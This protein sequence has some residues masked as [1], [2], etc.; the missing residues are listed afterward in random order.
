[1][2]ESI[3][4]VSFSG[5]EEKEEEFDDEMKVELS[6]SFYGEEEEEEEEEEDEK[7]LAERWIK[8]SQILPPEE[9]MGLGEAA[10]LID[11]VYGN[12]PCK[13]VDEEQEES[14]AA[15]PWT[16]EDAE[17][18][19]KKQQEYLDK[20]KEYANLGLCDVEPTGDYTTQ[21][22][23]ELSHAE[24][25]YYLNVSGGQITKTVLQTSI[26]NED[27]KNAES[28]ARVYLVDIRVLGTVDGE[29][30]DCTVTG[31]YF[32]ESDEISLS[33]P[34]TD[35]ATEI[36]RGKYCPKKDNYG[37]EFTVREIEDVVRCYE[38]VT[39]QYFCECSG[40]LA[41]EITEEV[42]ISCPEDLNIRCNRQYS[43]WTNGYY[44]DDGN[45]VPGKYYCD[46]YMG[47]RTVLG[48]YISCDIVLYD[49]MGVPRAR[50]E[51]KSVMS[52]AWYYEE[53][54]C[55]PPEG[56]LPKCQTTYRKNPGDGKIDETRLSNYKARYGDKLD[57]I[58][59]SPEDGDC[60]TIKTVI[61]D[62]ALSCCDFVT[63]IV[64]DIEN[65]FE[66][67]GDY[68][69]GYIVFSGGRAPYHVSV[70]G[71]GFHLGNGVRD[72]IVQHTLV[73]IYTAQ[74]C[75]VVK[76]TVDDGCST[77]SGYARATNGS[78]LPVDGIPQPSCHIPGD[79]STRLVNPGD[80]VISGK[81][82]AENIYCDVGCSLR[83][84]I[85][86]GL[87]DLD[88]VHCEDAALLECS[89]KDSEGTLCASFL[90]AF[91][92]S[93]FSTG[94]V[95]GEWETIIAG[96]STLHRWCDIKE[97]DGPC[98]W[99]LL[100]REFSYD[101]GETV[102]A[103]DFPFAPTYYSFACTAIIYEWVC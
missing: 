27:R 91:N 59:V 44:D 33:A 89:A 87:G 55:V 101:G 17:E 100:Y 57:L 26:K 32:E 47:S 21:I 96:G 76:V 53:R 41:N 74:A 94:K 78:W 43:N 35:D 95:C 29:V 36:D 61:S 28:P 23:V 7:E 82:M 67:I 30:G 42:T 102:G 2:V 84:P 90:N 63:P 12:D 50:W 4:N 98:A 77:A 65:S 24:G 8:L 3:L 80:T 16:K 66:V 25:Q 68:S 19:R 15:E 20:V 99:W 92:I 88:V 38:T 31:T 71:S 40:G 60:G 73:K 56:S 97:H 86:E 14:I 103:Y 9:E 72:G 46:K 54:C 34:S 58:P 49:P 22:T 69:V 1:M 51:D 52:E 48:D 45:W 18:N 62:T 70:R 11:N 6:V 37:S 13:D 81:Y 5:T 83:F 10:E 85:L 93:S 75:G 39:T 64:W 79:Y